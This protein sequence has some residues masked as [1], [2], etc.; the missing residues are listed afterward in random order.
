MINDFINDNGDKKYAFVTLMIDNIDYISGAIVLSYSLR[1]VGTL[2]DLIILINDNIN[3]KDYN[4]LTNFYDVI[5]KIKPKKIKHENKIQQIIL[6]KL[7]GL[8]LINYEKICLIDIDSLILYNI[9]NLF[10]KETP[11]C[12]NTNN[13]LNTGLI[14]LKP[15]L[16]IYD[17]IN[18][19]LL[20]ESFLIL[21]KNS[22]KPLII[23][24]KK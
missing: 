7:E 13:E 6:N 15:D 8:K 10:N 23:I 24:L 12:I 22:K 16:K 19:L 18:N 21:L 2:C 17:K 4:L 1:K 9:D 14:L 5:I 11:S 3:E 20:N